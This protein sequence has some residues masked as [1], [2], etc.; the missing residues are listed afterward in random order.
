MSFKYEVASLKNETQI[1]SYITQT[2]F[3]LTPKFI[4]FVYEEVEGQ[5]IGFLL[6]D[7]QGRY[8]DIDDLDLCQAT[9]QKLN[10]IGIVYGD[11]NKYYFL[12]TGKKVM[13]INFEVSTRIGINRHEADSEMQQLPNETVR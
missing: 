4:G 2:S 11:L 7:I 1:Y 13:V 8:H 9:V 10:E 5:V 6:E 3:A 12:I